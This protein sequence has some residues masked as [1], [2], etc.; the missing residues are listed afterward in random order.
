MTALT[1]PFPSGRGSREP[2]FWET[3]SDFV[4]AIREGLATAA[5]YEA[6]ECK[7]DAELAQLGLR[8]A[9]IPRVALANRGR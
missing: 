8:R 7:T 5:R 4:A 1:L 6:M 9:D 3:V 2:G